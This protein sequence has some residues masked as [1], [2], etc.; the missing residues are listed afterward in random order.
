VGLALRASKPKMALP[1]IVAG[2]AVAVIGVL[3]VVL[4][5]KPRPS[6]SER[7]IGKEERG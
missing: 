3:V 2:L 6:P 5:R 1:L 7:R 4:A